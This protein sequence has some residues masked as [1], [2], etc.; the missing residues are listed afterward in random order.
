MMGDDLI[1]VMRIEENEE[2][3]SDS[4]SKDQDSTARMTQDT[5]YGEAMRADKIARE[6]PAVCQD[7]NLYVVEQGRIVFQMRH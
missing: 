3:V 2:C 4:S 7:S 6:P 1:H 5:E